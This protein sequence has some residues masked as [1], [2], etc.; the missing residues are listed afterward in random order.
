MPPGSTAHR[1]GIGQLARQTALVRHRRRLTATIVIVLVLGACSVHESTRSGGLVPPASP[2]V[3]APPLPTVVTIS[4]DDDLSAALGDTSRAS[5][6][7]STAATLAEPAVTESPNATSSGAQD[8]AVTQT[9]THSS[10]TVQP[11][12]RA[13]A[14][15]VL[16]TAVPLDG[17][18]E[19]LLAVSGPAGSSVWPV[20]VADTPE[21]RQRGLMGVTDFAALGG[22]AA[23]VFVF[24]SDTSGAFWMRD[25]PLP[26]RI[27]YVDAGGV[28]VSATD[29]VPCLPPTPSQECDRYY[30]NGPYRIAVEH[31]W[32]PDY[33]LG[34]GTATT[35]T[36]ER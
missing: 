10:P 2:S 28:V 13:D 12:T 31:P 7:L 20:I 3:T 35:V 9:T 25:T 30:P 5:S 1:V 4:V 18:G 27:T 29:M 23:M 15:Q 32:S 21:A 16:A 19:G 36:L 34:L 11:G 33:D 24:D 14:D 17:F 8:P 6:P 26:L 22:Y